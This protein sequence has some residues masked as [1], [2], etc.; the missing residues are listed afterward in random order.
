[1]IQK[2][3]A[4]GSWMLPCLVIFFCSFIL[5]WKLQK[6][7]LNRSTLVSATATYQT[8]CP[9]IVLS[10][11]FCPYGCCPMILDYSLPWVSL[12]N[13]LI[14]LNTTELVNFK[15]MFQMDKL[16]HGNQFYLEFDKVQFC[17]HFLYSFPSMTFLIN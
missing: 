10:A 9:F 13:L 4:S 17:N 2:K 5:I 8:K 14:F 1:M 16:H 6:C 15:R 3:S 12:G 11:L 7:S